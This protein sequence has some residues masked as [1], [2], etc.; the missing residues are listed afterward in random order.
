MLN[1]CILLLYYT[2][3]QLIGIP[4]KQNSRPSPIGGSPNKPSEV[5]RPPEPRAPQEQ[6]PS[7]TI[8]TPESVDTGNSNKGLQQDQPPTQ[9]SNDKVSYSTVYEF[10]DSPNKSTKKP[11]QTGSTKPV[12][13]ESLNTLKNAAI[14]IGI[15]ILV[16]F[17][18]IFVLRKWKFHSTP[19]FRQKLSPKRTLETDSSFVKDLYA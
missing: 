19:Q 14:G 10:E 12:V 11:L 9:T 7:N 1:P 3:S 18:A 16:A 17:I 15:I 4:T 2:T 8:P 5:S 13:D 6:K